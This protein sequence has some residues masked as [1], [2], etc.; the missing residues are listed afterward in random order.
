MFRIIILIPR[1]FTVCPSLLSPNNTTHRQGNR[2]PKAPPWLCTSE[3]ESL[4]HSTQLDPNLPVQ[5]YQPLPS[6]VNLPAAQLYRSLPCTLQPLPL[7]PAWTY[8]DAWEVYVSF[9]N[10]LLKHWNAS[11]I[12]QVGS[13]LIPLLIFITWFSESFFAT[14][15]VLLYLPW[16]I[17]T[18]GGQEI[19]LKFGIPYSL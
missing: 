16:E 4:H 3:W 19:F 6:Y 5:L 8:L 15:H 17:I 11:L 10:G 14:H 2:F 9:K 12:S 13:N 18:P 1:I 7:A